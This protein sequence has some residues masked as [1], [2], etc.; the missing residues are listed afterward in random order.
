[1]LCNKKLSLYPVHGFWCYNKLHEHVAMPHYNVWA[2][3][4]F[5]GFNKCFR[6]AKTVL[7]LQLSAY[8]Q[9]LVLLH[10]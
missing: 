4:S 10:A 3:V 5:C 6:L 9:P 8:H 1:M 2:M 7:L